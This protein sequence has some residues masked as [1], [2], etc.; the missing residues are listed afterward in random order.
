MPCP[1]PTWIRLFLST[2]TYAPKSASSC[3]RTVED[4]IMVRVV[5]VGDKAIVRSVLVWQHAVSASFP[6]EKEASTLRRSTLN[7]CFRIVFAMSVNV[8]S[9]FADTAVWD[10]TI[11]TTSVRVMREFCNKAVRWRNS[12]C[13]NNVPW[14][15]DKGRTRKNRFRDWDASCRAQTSQS[16]Q[17]EG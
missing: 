4:G 17:S 14:R 3:Q 6:R 13:T 7:V 15:E 1:S 12:M 5:K 10:C 8:I 9:V 2:E 16:L 11:C